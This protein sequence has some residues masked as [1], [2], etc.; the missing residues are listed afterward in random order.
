AMLGLLRGAARRAPAG[1]RSYGTSLPIP[2]PPSGS[3]REQ[4]HARMMLPKYS[5]SNQ[6]WF[7][8]FGACNAGAYT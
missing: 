5:L 3:G 2:T 6:K 4:F 8:L 1:A 7:F